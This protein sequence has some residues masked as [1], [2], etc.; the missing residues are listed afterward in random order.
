MGV[1]KN[2]GTLVGGPLNW[3]LFYLGAFNGVP[4]FWENAHMVYGV[5]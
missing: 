5:L 4:R 3:L 1:S 2:R